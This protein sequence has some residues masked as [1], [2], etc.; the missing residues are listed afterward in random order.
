MSFILIPDLQDILKFLFE[1][2]TCVCLLE[3]S[4]D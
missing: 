2:F 3:D 1:K 4:I